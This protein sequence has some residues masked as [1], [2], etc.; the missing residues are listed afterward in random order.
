MPVE[1]MIIEIVQTLTIGLV[2]LAF[3]VPIIKMI[4]RR[5]EQRGD[6]PPKALTGIADRLEHIERAVD[7]MAVEIE[8]ISEGQRFTTRLLAERAESSRGP[9]AGSGGAPGAER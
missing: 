9:K 2:A 4:A 7:T 1:F 5:V 3:G 6:V 8:R